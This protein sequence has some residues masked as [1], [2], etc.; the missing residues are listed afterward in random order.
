[1]LLD[2]AREYHFTL[3]DS[4]L[5]GDSRKDTMAARAAGCESILLD[6]PYNRDDPADRRVSDLSEAVDIILGENR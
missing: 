5:I 4:W 2:L 6:R 3:A 1:M